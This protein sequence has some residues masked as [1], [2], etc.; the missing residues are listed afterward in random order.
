M[1]TKKKEIVGLIPVKGESDRVKKK[2]LREFSDTN[3]FELKL[4]QLK[5]VVGFSDLVVSSEDPTILETA[6]KAGCSIHERDPKYSTSKVAMSEVYSAIGSEVHGEH[7]AWINVTNPL[8]VADF[9]TE[10]IKQYQ[11]MPEEYDCLLSVYELQDNVIYKGKPLNFPRYPWP[12]SQDL[13]PVLIM[14]FVI[15]I[16]RRKDLI[17]W[18]S[19]VGESPYFLIRDPIESWDIDFQIDF[20][21]CQMIY[22]KRKLAK[23]NHPSK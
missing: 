23:K 4:S 22:E 10:G 18:G 14:S 9:Y 5:G 1:N 11:N 3:L 8:A 15:N 21:F 19:C 7:I 16:L 6:Q 12:R 20:D 17:R 2:N 13:E